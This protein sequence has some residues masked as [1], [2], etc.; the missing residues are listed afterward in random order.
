[1]RVAGG[2]PGCALQAA[3][4][5]AARRGSCCGREPASAEAGTP[6]AQGGGSARCA[7]APMWDTIL[8]H[9]TSWSY[10]GRTC[11]LRAV[12][13]PQDPKCSQS[14]FAAPA[15]AVEEKGSSD[16][17]G[18]GAATA[19]G[20]IFLLGAVGLGGFLLWKNRDAL[21]NKVAS[22][23]GGERCARLFFNPELK[24]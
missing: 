9:C 13:G 3:Q 23:R 14:A 17:G 4:P 18:S 11:P 2:G 19:F 16:K 6:S 20:V 15:R 8:F 5:I 21:R 7:S 1:M 10:W 12:A 24:E 22:I